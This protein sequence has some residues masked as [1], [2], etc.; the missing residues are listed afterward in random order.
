MVKTKG[1]TCK[2]QSQ[3]REVTQ[4]KILDSACRAVGEKGYSNTALEDIA[5]GAGVTEGPVYHYFK[6]KKQLFTK[7]TEQM[8]AE[9]V[10]DIHALDFSGGDASL[11]Q[12]WDVFLNYCQKPGFVQ[13]VLIDATHILGR[14]RWQGTAVTTSILNLLGNTSFFTEKNMGEEEKGLISRMVIAALAEVALTLGNNPQYD[15]SHVLRK[16]ITLFAADKK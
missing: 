2:T 7:V 4:Q 9:F 8:E 11:L 10:S 16:L 15:A 1:A 5:T 12:I 14:E 6:N 13:V 3:R